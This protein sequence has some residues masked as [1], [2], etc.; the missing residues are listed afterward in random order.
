MQ[1]KRKT[2][3][4]FSGDWMG[5]LTGNK[6]WAGNPGC[7]PHT[8][9]WFLVSTLAIKLQTVRSL[10]D[11][12][13]PCSSQ[14]FTFTFCFGR[15]RC[16]RKL[17]EPT[18]GR[19]EEQSRLEELMPCEQIPYSIMPDL[20]HI[21]HWTCLI[22]ACVFTTK[23]FEPIFSHASRNV[24][25]GHAHLFLVNQTCLPITAHY[26]TSSLY[27]KVKILWPKIQMVQKPQKTFW[28]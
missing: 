10:W 21:L 13:N 11:Q 17:S 12:A 2:P 4:S 14:P 26:T 7:D 3:V 23:Y 19:C 6:S 27:F 28:C 16:P 18:E 20:C 5:H 1:L 22:T 25:V 15:Q 24:P 8:V 9:S